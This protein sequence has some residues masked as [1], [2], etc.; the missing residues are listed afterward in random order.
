MSKSHVEGGEKRLCVSLSYCPIS[1][2]EALGFTM[3]ITNILFRTEL[4]G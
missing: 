4:C 3:L 2:R 1:I